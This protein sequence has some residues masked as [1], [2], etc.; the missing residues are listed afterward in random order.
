MLVS[1]GHWGQSTEQCRANGV[2]ELL[3]TPWGFPDTTVRISDTVN[4]T[5][6]VVSDF[7]FL[8]SAVLLYPETTS[9]SSYNIWVFMTTLC[10]P[11]LNTVEDNNK[12][13]NH[14]V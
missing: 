8:S 13:V 1:S 14:K 6:Y 12:T 7:Y 10:F 9:G 11:G 2:E 3:E 4:P 5:V